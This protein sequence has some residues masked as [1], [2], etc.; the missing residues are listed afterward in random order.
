[1]ICFIYGI[2]LFF[3]D[4]ICLQPSIVLPRGLFS[5]LFLWAPYEQKSFFSTTYNWRKMNEQQ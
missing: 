3:V 2:Y 4:Q 5:E 1:L